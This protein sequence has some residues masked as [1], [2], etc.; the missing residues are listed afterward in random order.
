MATYRQ[1]QE[2]VRDRYHWTPKTCWIAHCKELTGLPL[3]DAP[4]RRARERRQPC[5]R[6]KRE[7]IFQ[8]LRHFMILVVLTTIGTL[9]VGERI[10]AQQAAASLERVEAADTDAPSECRAAPCTES[11]RVCLNTG[12]FVLAIEAHED[13]RVA[14]AALTTDQAEDVEYKDPGE[15]PGW[16]FLGLYPGAALVSQAIAFGDDGWGWSTTE[17]EE[18]QCYFVTALDG[19]ARLYELRVAVSW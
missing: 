6:D 3:R 19:R 8:A 5:P 11:R 4:N 16:K 12:A 1:I 17:V 10:A 2:W 9:A 18:P 13:S 15:M 14:S 7:A